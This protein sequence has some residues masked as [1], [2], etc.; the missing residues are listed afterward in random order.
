MQNNELISLLPSELGFELPKNSIFD[1]LNAK[2]L[3]KLRV[4]HLEL[5][6]ILYR[7][8]ISEPK[9]AN[10]FNLKEDTKIASAITRLIIERLEQKL[11]MRKK[12]GSI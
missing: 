3:E 10:A 5:M 4:N 11:E 9:L 12:Y 8:D 7:I 2:V 6:N 1:A